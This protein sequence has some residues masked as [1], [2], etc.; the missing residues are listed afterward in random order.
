M[1]SLNVSREKPVDADLISTTR[2]GLDGKALA[3]VIATIAG[4]KLE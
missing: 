1:N 3:E 2:F 4:K